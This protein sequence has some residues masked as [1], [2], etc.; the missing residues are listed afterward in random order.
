MNTRRVSHW[1]ITSFLLAGALGV[2]CVAA[3]P[4][5]VADPEVLGE[6]EQALDPAIWPVCWADTA[7][8]GAGVIPSKCPGEEKDGALCY[9]LCKAG[10]EGVGPVC[11]ESCPPDAHDD[12]AL[13]RRDAK[14]IAANNSSCPWYDKCGLTFAKGCSKCPVGYINDG[15]TCRMNV[16]IWAKKSYGRGAGTPMHCPASRPDN[17]AGLCY[18]ACGADQT[19]V[20]PVC[21]YDCPATHPVACGAG[22]AVNN[23]ACATALAQQIVTPI[24]LVMEIVAEDPAAIA[25][26]LEVANAYALPICDN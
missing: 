9:P 19:G 1:V 8:R 6:V 18:E 11:W 21:W 20:G 23:D 13:C 25:T 26:A 5:D 12:G 10:Y 4:E 14:I 17:D 24:Q 2:G 22:C 16:Q 7:V 3:T 15:C